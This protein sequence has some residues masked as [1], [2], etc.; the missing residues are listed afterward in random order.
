MKEKTTGTNIIPNTKINSESSSEHSQ[1]ATS[2]KTVAIIGAGIAGLTLSLE[3]CRLGIKPILL[4]RQKV[5]G[6]LA[7]SIPYAG[8]NI[9]IGP[10]YTILP[11]NS[12][13]TE[14]IFSLMGENEIIHLPDEIFSKYCKTN[15]NGKLLSTYP[16][17]MEF[18]CNSGFGFF[19]KSIWEFLKTKLKNV[20]KKLEFDNARDY[21]CSSY[22][23]FLYEKWF[24]PYL[25]RRYQDDEPPLSKVLEQFPVPT[26]KSILSNLRK[27]PNQNSSKYI[28]FS[29]QGAII[30]YF[31][32]GMI[33]LI[34]KIENEILRLGGEIHLDI[35][36]QAI[37][38]QDTK[39]MIMANKNGKEIKLQPDGIVYATSPQIALQWFENPPNS[40]ILKNSNSRTHI[41]MVYLCIDKPKLFDSWVIN[42]Y[43]LDI[44]FAR[45]A[46]QNF[47]S[48]A[49]APPG[50]SLLNIEIRTTENNPIWKMNESKLYNLV[51]HDLEKTKIL[52]REE[53]DDY[54][55]I[56]LKNLYQKP[57][58]KKDNSKEKMAE[59]IDSHKNE[60]AVAGEKSMVA[61]EILVTEKSDKT[62]LEKIKYGEGIYKLFHR[63][64]NLAGVISSALK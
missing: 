38:H 1:Y 13:F 7:T 56:K 46:Q 60:Y 42:F 12:E 63:S 28:S 52:S 32:G 29:E 37:E 50:K 39:K 30:C 40:L 51:V 11:K 22:G 33:S 53:V 2:E 64:R 44:C 58:F 17:L 23:E 8:Y 41:I 62:E 24:E 54:K 4:E 19:I 55:I 36:I 20:S 35:D 14:Y 61:P 45:I 6:G 59:F 5:C 43:D 25:H 16:T 18:I 47:L 3:L 48:K 15:F 9:D 26:F 57:L 21:L 49:I 27:K 31:N 10:H 34:K